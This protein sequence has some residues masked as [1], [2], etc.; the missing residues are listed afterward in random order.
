M[1]KGRECFLEQHNTLEQAAQNAHL[2]QGSSVALG[3]FDGVHIGHQAVIG[4]A[5]DY[6]RKHGLTPAVFSF[7]L[8]LGHTMNGGRLLDETSK[9]EYIRQLGVEHY[10]EPDFQS[11]RDVSPEEFV[12]KILA[13]D[14]GAKAVFCGESY[15]FG[16]KAAG[17]ITLLKQLCQPLGIQVVIV[18]DTLYEGQVVSS[19][20][21]RTALAKG[22][23]PLVNAMLGRPY[24]IRFP[25]LH[26]QGLGH[27]LGF[28]TTNQIYP[29]G[30]AQP[31]YGIYVTKVQ[32]DGVWY[33]GA[34]GFG[35]RPTVNPDGQNPTCETFIP[36][37]QGSLY[38]DELELA[39]YQYLSPSRK[40]DSLEELRACIQNAAEQAVAYFQPK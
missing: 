38:G 21:I 14:C 23:I 1:W 30:F 37:F 6:A 28:P 27:T 26:G 11:M 8:P 3:F 31:L 33:P 17:D 5:V 9:Y 24:S 19:T 39:F 10:I 40:F 15:T 29:A 13:G 4:G 36:G 12:Q 2:Q 16:S 25:V 34:T 18:P 22:D 20:R 32:I 7:R 35:T